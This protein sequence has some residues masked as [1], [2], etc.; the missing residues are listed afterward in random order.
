M[1]ATPIE[2][3][4]ANANEEKLTTISKDAELVTLINVFVVEPENQQRVVDLLMEATEEVMCKL[5]GFICANIHKSL[6][7]TRVTNYAQWRS[8][9]DFRG[10]FQNQEALSHMPA[11]GKIAKSDPTLYQV[12]YTKNL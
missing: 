7:G 12:C 10:I 6:D 3:S 4:S 5:P 9:E 11:I 8:V 1:T 2:T